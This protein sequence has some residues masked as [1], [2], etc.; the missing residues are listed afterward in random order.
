MVEEQGETIV[1]ATLDKATVADVSVYLSL[2][3]T[4]L[5]ET[6]YTPQSI[7]ILIK[8]GETSGTTTLI[9]N[10]DTDIEENETIIIEVAAINGANASQ[11]GVQSHTVT[12]ID[13]DF[14]P[15]LVSLHVSPDILT[16]SGGASK[17]TASLG[18]ATFEDVTVNLAFS[19]TA[20]NGTDYVVASQNIVIAAGS[21]IGSVVSHAI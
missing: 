4:A 9:A 11:D 15:V 8:N 10:Q 17:I 12:L 18:K 21:T 13:D 7:A 14:I 5:H 20:T 6:D 19:G 1:T 2:L 3:G 16:E